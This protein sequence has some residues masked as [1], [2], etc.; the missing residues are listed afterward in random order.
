[1]DETLLMLL[2]DKHL[3]WL[4]LH[5]TGAPHIVDG[6]VLLWPAVDG[7]NLLIRAPSWPRREIL[8]CYIAYFR[9]A[10]FAA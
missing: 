5:H 6:E 8:G 4:L 1:M 10:H 3:L 9:D 2:I 7:Q